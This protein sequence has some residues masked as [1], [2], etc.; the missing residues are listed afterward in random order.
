MYETTLRTGRCD[1]CG[2]RR[3]GG[4]LSC[5]GTPVLFV[6]SA[7]DPSYFWAGVSDEWRH[8]DLFLD[9][10]QNLTEMTADLYL[11]RKEEVLS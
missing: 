2:C 8:V 4:E 11:T 3:Q 6:C 5:N 10:Y 9:V 7:C 1:L